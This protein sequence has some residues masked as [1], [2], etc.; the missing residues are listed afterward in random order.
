MQKEGHA[1]ETQ[2]HLINLLLQSETKFTVD[3]EIQ[4]IL[5]SV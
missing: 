4:K 2:M 1:Q 3:K 5:E